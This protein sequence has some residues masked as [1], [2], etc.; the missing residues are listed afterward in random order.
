MKILTFDLEEWFHF[1][2]NASTKTENQ[3]KNYEVR[4]HQNMDRIFEVLETTNTKASF[5]V[6]GWIAERYPEV[7]REFVIEVMILVVTALLINWYMSKA[8]KSLGWTWIGLLKL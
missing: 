5:F 3:W 7:V 8:K 4:I 2:D 6:L 1:L